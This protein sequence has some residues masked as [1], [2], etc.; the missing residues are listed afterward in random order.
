LLTFV[1]VDTCES[2]DQSHLPD[3]EDD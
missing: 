1:F 2:L 3:G